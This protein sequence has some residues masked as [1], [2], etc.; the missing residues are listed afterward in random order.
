L[1]RILTYVA[2][3]TGWDF[4]HIRYRTTFDEL[5]MVYE[6]AGQLNG[7]FRQGKRAQEVDKEALRKEVEAIHKRIGK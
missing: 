1:G 3:W 2:C 7:L 5:M 6:Y 4:E